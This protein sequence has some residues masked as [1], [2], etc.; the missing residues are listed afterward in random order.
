MH[1]VRIV[2]TDMKHVTDLEKFA[3][4]EIVRPYWY[5]TSWYKDAVRNESINQHDPA[6]YFYPLADVLKELKHNDEFRKCS[7]GRL[8]E[9]G[10]WITPTYVRH[11]LVSYLI[12]NGVM[13]RAVD[14]N[15]VMESERLSSSVNARS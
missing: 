12:S 15:H 2:S 11:P 14:K 6:D 5:D 3:F 7:L 13:K 1:G 10:V 8:K 9:C 4:E